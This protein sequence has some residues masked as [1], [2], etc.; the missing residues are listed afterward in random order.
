MKK[1]LNLILRVALGIILLLLVYFSAMPVIP[2]RAVPADAPTVRFSA[3]R[4]MADLEVV[5]R[6]PHAAGS[7]PQAQVRDYIVS[8]VTALGLNPEIQTNGQISNILVQLPGTDPTLTVLVT[9]HYD[10]HPPSPGAGDNGISVV[11]MLE[12]IRVLRASLPLRNDI[13]FLFTDGEELGWKGAITFITKYPKAKDEIGVVLCFDA[14]PDNAPLTLL[15]TSPGDA[16]LVRQMSGMPLSLWAG[17]WN[18]REERTEMDTDFDAFQPAGFIGVAIEN[19]A[20]GTRYHTDR[21][22]V[23][24]ISPNL[25]QADG[26][27]MLALASRFGTIDL[28]TRTEGPDLVFF[29][30]P[31]VGL[32]AYPGWVMPVLSGLGILALLACVILAWQRVRFSLGRFLL[33]TIGVLLGILL[34]VLCAQLAWGIILKGNAAEVAAFGGFEAS[35]GWLTGLMVMAGLLLMIIL[36]MLSRLLGEINLA[37]AAAL[38]YLLV[39]FTAHQLI[40]AD[41]P[42]TTAYIV[43]PFLGSVVGI[44]ILLFTKKPVWKVVLLSFSALLVLVLMIPFLKLATYTREDAWIPVLVLSVWITLLSPQFGFIFGTGHSKKESGHEPQALKSDQTGA[45][46]SSLLG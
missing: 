29:T 44:G 23:D 19:E 46:A 37:A 31:L 22:T 2:P 3:D 14:R 27:T 40:E 43:W 7:D 26:Q 34:I 1:N 25:V 5:A 15:E 33:S 39:W 13:L 6:V 11:A 35:A 10:S 4:A 24:A 32:V 12:S 16:W 30:L 8:E 45:P 21:D 18:N 17:S 38:V 41:N 9:G 20:S 42:L 36:A 28:R